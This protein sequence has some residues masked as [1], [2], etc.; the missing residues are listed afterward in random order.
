MG[1]MQYSVHSK[2]ILSPIIEILKDTV[3]ACI[4]IGR[5][6]ETQS[7]GEYVLQTTFLRMTGASEQKLKCICWEMATN[8]Y[9][10]RY[11]YLKKNYG[12]C[13][14]YQDKCSIYREMVE[15]TRKMDPSFNIARL[16][17]DI[18][19]SSKEEELINQKIRETQRLQEK[20]EKR[21]LTE[22]EVK[23]LSKGIRDN[24]AKKGLG[25]K[26]KLHLCKVI[27]FEN[28]QERLANVIGNSLVAQWGQHK[29]NDYKQKWNTM[30]GWGFAEG[31]NL[32]VKELQDLY[33]DFVYAHRNRCA[34]NLAS[35]RNNL[36]TLK[37]LADDRF[38]YSNYYF[39]FSV[40]LLLDDIFI[41]LYRA[42][43]DSLK[44]MSEQF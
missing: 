1:G 19:T 32:F 44:R 24:Y 12:E 16:F 26:E 35:C 10:Y 39:Y 7:L 6:I 21:K 27:E 34:H 31:D 9:D 11:H 42:Y 3:N 23:K 41:R 25:E 20:K 15:M 28:I 22:D 14:S 37:T 30:S 13:S 17:D 43:Q 33:T 38:V 5:G 36:P 18:D 40:L 2:F 4:G 8:D 29:Y